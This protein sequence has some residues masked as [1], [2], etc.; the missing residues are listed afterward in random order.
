MF[1]RSVPD[2]LQVV[3]PFLK[4]GLE[5]GESCL[6][7][8]APP[9]P[10][11][12]AAK[13]IDRQLPLTAQYRARGQLDIVSYQQWYTGK[14]A[15]DPQQGWP[16]WAA[17]ARD[18]ERQGFTGIRVMGNP[19]WLETSDPWTQSGSF[20]QDVRDSIQHERILALCSYPTAQ[21]NADRMLEV[22]QHHSHALLPTA[23]HQWTLTAVTS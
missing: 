22:L 16:R 5:G 4:A 14:G 10:V 11:D 12:E 18:A 17:K 19:L 2:L 21:C 3:I 8:T 20:E 7:I 13:A 1:Y 23:F 15:L 9:L 6:W